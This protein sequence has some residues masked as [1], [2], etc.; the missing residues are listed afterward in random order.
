MNV[1]Q[2]ALFRFL[3]AK[4]L[5]YEAKLAELREQIMAWLAYVPASF[6]HY[7][8]HTIEHS[9]EI[10]SQLS[11]LLFED[12][13]PTKPS[14][15]L[16]AVEAYILCVASYLH[17]AGMVCSDS[18]KARILAS[19][20]WAEWIGPD[21]PGEHRWQSIDELRANA[22]SASNPILHFWADVQTRFLVAEYV[23]ARHHLRA[24]DLIEQHADALGRFAFGDPILQRTI[25]AVCIGHGYHRHQLEDVEHYPEQ[26]DVRGEKVN[27][28]FMAYLFRLGD[29]L[30]MAHDR[31][32]PLLLNASCPLPAE[33][34]AHWTQYQRIVHRLTSPTRI[35]ISAECKN[36]QEHR[37]LRDWCQWIVDEAQNAAVVMG[38]ASR[39]NNWHAPIAKIVGEAPSIVIRP[40]KGATY[41]PSEWRFQMDESAILERLSSDLYDDK[42]AFVRELLQNA[43]DATRCKCYQELTLLGLPTPE[44]AWEIDEEIRAK[45]AIRISV[46]EAA[47]RSQLSEEDVTHQWLTI[48]DS[49]TGMDQEVIEKYFLQIGRSYYTSN[50][51]R[52]RFTFA[53][54]S[55]FGIG[56]LSAFSVSDHIE[57]ETFNPDSPRP[58][59]PI[60]LTLQQP[61]SYLLT[62]RGTRNTSGTSIKIRM[63][64]PVPP[65][66]ILDYLRRLCTR[67]EF[68]IHVM[69]EGKGHEIRAERPSD[70]ATSV[71]DASDLSS[72]FEIR[73]L[74]IGYPGVRGE[75]YV[76][77]HI[78]KDGERW[79]KYGW[80]RRY[81]PRHHPGASILRLPNPM[82]AFHGLNLTLHE[83][84]NYMAMEYPARLDVRLAEIGPS[85]SRRFL[86]GPGHTIAAKAIEDTLTKALTIHIASLHFENPRDRFQYLQGLASK[87]PFMDFWASA[88]DTIAI[89]RDGKQQLCSLTWLANVETFSVVV[90]QLQPV[91]SSEK[92][93]IQKQWRPEFDKFAALVPGIA[94]SEFDI[95]DMA[96]SVRKSL[97]K[98]MY[99]ARVRE[100][101]KKTCVIEWTKVEL[102]SRAPVKYSSPSVYSCAFENFDAISFASHRTTDSTYE[103]VH[104]NA[105]HAFIEWLYRFKQACEANSCH[106]D[107]AQFE[108][109]AELLKTP[110]S[111]RGYEIQE[112]SSFIETLVKAGNLPNDLLPPKF[113]GEN[114]K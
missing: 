61:R 14:V 69:V 72:R 68:P 48:E 97:F 26:R 74:P 8:R 108:T 37:V 4:G 27:V 13:N 55:R 105:G 58:N 15:E 98:G 90:G 78:R 111:H 39:H 24:G 6:P 2:T 59:G 12:G 65:S 38:R 5:H 89:F 21:G 95:E 9:E 30:D 36:Q 106:L 100:I 88:P 49:G 40:A 7:T 99:S 50:E 16:S 94:L 91:I 83:Q 104:L 67:V 54:S 103:A 114:F 79:G 66:E 62:D 28:R 25:A 19:S 82:S 23:R 101:A 44:Y 42:L 51:F 71:I 80:M 32:C 64:D 70:F 60:R 11:N 102:H 112:F 35:E 93:A 1:E 96:D 63:N 17:D 57:V 86:R 34:L 43:F 84:Y 45:H 56:F 52:R 53:P 20:E 87:F 92:D 109:A 75:V 33:S 47:E 3:A 110:L 22:M 18:E 10:I 76:A 81:Y 31:A 73:P 46:T 113:S 77:I 107:A 29:L 41:I 85:L